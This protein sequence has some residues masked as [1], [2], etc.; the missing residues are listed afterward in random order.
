M[1]PA[2][3]PLPVSTA[4]AR[5]ARNGASSELRITQQQNGIYAA[6]F[7]AMASPCEILIETRD[8]K[9]ARRAAQA[10]ADEA[11]RI[12]RKYSRYREDSVLSGLNR[13]NGASVV[14]DDETAALL[15]FAECCFVVSDGLFDVTSGILRRVWTFDGS[16]RVPAPADVDACRAFVGFQRLL[17]KRPLLNLPAGMELDFGGICKEYAVDR[18]LAA[19]TARFSGAVLVNFGGDLCASGAPA[20]GPWS[21]GVERPDSDREARL[22][23]DLTQG[24]LATSGDTHRFLMRDGVRYGH[25]LDPRTGWPVKDAPRSVTVAAGGCT[26][27]GMLS[28]LAMLRGSEAE[29]FLTEEGVKF[30]CLR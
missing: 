14:V 6:T 15:D 5:S 13:S 26:Q 3:K 4:G 18:A 1:T 25:I 8:A 11:W 7:F 29:R 16:D 24:A 2:S 27:A 10:A 28:S 22:L 9:L 17:W 21:V 12:E 23:L 30:W 20:A 19:I